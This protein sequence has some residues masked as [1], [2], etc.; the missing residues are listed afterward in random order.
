MD[1]QEYSEQLK[2]AVN[3][4]DVIINEE[5]KT[6]TVKTD[7]PDPNDTPDNLAGPLLAK[8]HRQ[9]GLTVELEKLGYS[10]S[11]ENRQS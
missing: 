6:A 7:W 3:Q 1:T 11:W 2:Q 5:N 10:V 4:G 8:K 9:L